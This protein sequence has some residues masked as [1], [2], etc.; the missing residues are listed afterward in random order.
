VTYIV[1][2]F[3]LRSWFELK[4]IIIIVSLGE[5]HLNSLPLSTIRRINTMQYPRAGGGV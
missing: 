3:V 2:C 1:N 5:H 4:L